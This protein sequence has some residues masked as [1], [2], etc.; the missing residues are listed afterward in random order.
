[1]DHMLFPL[2]RLHG[3]VWGAPEVR[4]CE[5]TII[6]AIKRQA[7]LVCPEPLLCHNVNSVLQMSRKACCHGRSRRST[8][9]LPPTIGPPVS[10]C[11]NLDLLPLELSNCKGNPA[12]TASQQYPIFT[13]KMPVV[14]TGFTVRAAFLKR[15]NTPRTDLRGA[16]QPK[17]LMAFHHSD[18]SDF[19]AMDRIP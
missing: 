16:G 14:C 13:P 6:A 10:Y 5:Q 19:L 8:L 15:I 9:D 4:P 2:A 12:S 17:N 1:M 7:G 11:K 18:D 3:P